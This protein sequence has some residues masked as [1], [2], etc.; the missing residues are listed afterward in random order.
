MVAKHIALDEID[1]LEQNLMAYLLWKGHSL[2][3]QRDLPSPEKLALWTT[4][5]I[6]KNCSEVQSRL[7]HDVSELYWG[8]KKTMQKLAPAISVLDDVIG[9]PWEGESPL[10]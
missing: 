6:S 9:V 10:M 5:Q 8:W 3:N 1:D 4:F 2:V 7:G